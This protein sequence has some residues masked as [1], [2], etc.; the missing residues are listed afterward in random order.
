MLEDKFNFSIR[1]EKWTRKCIKKLMKTLERVKYNHIQFSSIQSHSHVQLFATPWTAA[2]QASL[3]LI[4]SWNYLNSCALSRWCRP[5]I[6][7]SVVSFLSL[8][9]SFPASGTFQISQF[10]IWS[11]QRIGVSALASVL[12]MNIQ[13]WF[14]LGWTGCVNWPR[15]SLGFAG[16]P[17]VESLPA[18][19]GDG[20]LIPDPGRS[21]MLQSN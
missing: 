18:S 3:S 19:A 11:G 4:N 5:T 6:S 7:S 1:D 21:H 10:F 17:V 2:C 12:P 16:G 13:D 14:P 20:G 8:L 15:K 9:Q